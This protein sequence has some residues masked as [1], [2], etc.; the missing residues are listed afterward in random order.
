MR[1]NPCLTLLMISTL[2]MA[3]ALAAPPD[4]GRQRPPSRPQA[5][6]VWHTLR[7]IPEA[8]ARLQ[9]RF[10]G[11]PE[12]PYQ[13]QAVAGSTHCRRRAVLLPLQQGAVDPGPSWVLDERIVVPSAACPGLAV[14]L[15]L[16]RSNPVATSRP[17]DAQGRERI[18]L[19]QVREQSASPRLAGLPQWRAHWQLQGRCG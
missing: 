5:D 1:V 7:Q 13:L 2:L 6:G 15:T 11:Q 10:T 12:L 4:T 19:Q 8:C 17:R 14:E 18:Y 9:G 3:P 16:W